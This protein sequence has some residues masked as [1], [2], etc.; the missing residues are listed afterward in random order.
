MLGRANG[1]PHSWQKRATLG[2]EEG[3]E[4]VFAAIALVPVEM[5]YLKVRR[6]CGNS[7]CG[8]PSNILL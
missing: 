1:F 5:P 4:E 8:V 3:G 7:D 6:T 2:T